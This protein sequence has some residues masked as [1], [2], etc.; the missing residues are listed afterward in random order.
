M[1]R[2][3]SPGNSISATLLTVFLVAVAA[4]LV[5]PL[6][7]QAQTTSNAVPDFS[8]TTLARSIPENTAADTNVGAVIPAATDTDAGDTLTYSMEGADATSF[9]FDAATRQ[10]KTETGVTYDHE[11]KSIYSVTVKVDDGNGGTGTDTLAPTWGDA[12]SAVERLWSL[13]DPGGLAANADIEPRARLDAEL[14][15]GLTGPRGVGVATPYAGLGLAGEGARAWRAGA[16]WDLA[17]RFTLGLEAT[18]REPSTDDPPEHR[19]MLRG[20]LRW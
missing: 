18:R 19:L 1:Q 6:Q 12:S 9:T 2:P 5:L 8:D 4:L 20:A 10:I 17:P 15:Y 7:A 3:P 13:R 14:G 11:A 16:R